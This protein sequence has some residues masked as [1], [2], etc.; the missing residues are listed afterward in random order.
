[1]TNS[2][3]EQEELLLRSFDTSVVGKERETL[4]GLIKQDATIRKHLKQYQKIRTMLMRTEPDSFGPFF[5]ER[6][7]HMIKQRSQEIDFLI[8]FFFKKYQVVMLGVVVALLIT[9]LLFAEHL[10]VKALFGVEQQP[11]EQGFEIDLYK[12]LT[13]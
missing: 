8:F 11:I 5:S 1:M 12:T 9:N 2:L 7:L 6:I 3:N 13:P 10:T 4:A